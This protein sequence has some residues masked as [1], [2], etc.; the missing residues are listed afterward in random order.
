MRKSGERIK[1][2]ERILGGSDFVLQVLAQANEKLSRRTRTRAMCFDFK[3]L[4]QEVAVRLG[5][6]ARLLST[7]TKD[8]A[9][10]RARAALCHTAV[11]L[12]MMSVADVARELNLSPSMVSKAVSRAKRSAVEAWC[13]LTY[14]G[15]LACGIAGA[16]FADI[17]QH[18]LDEYDPGVCRYCS[19]SFIEPILG[20]LPLRVWPA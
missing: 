15:G 20:N 14:V 12:H 10:S 13:R 7:P 2:D 11:R 16:E 9:V 1:G 4:M 5:I 6:D 3:R 18:I 19:R 17:K 8:R